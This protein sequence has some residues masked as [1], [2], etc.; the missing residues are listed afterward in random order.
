MA[1]HIDNS[2]VID[3]PLQLVWDMT[4]DIAGWPQLFSEYAETEI[5]A[6]SENTVRFRLTTKPDEQGRVFSWVSER[7]AEPVTW[8]VRARRLDFGVFKYMNLFWEYQEI[9]GA[10]VL[11]RW[12]QD[13]EVRPDAP[14]D[15]AGMTEHLNRHTRTQQQHI[16]KTIE[17]VARKA[18]V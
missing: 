16:K 15:D 3:A 14:A 7:V 6:Q 9:D 12:V 8:T 2:V 13:F 10:G 17:L 11:M 4:N 1:G 18:A 5:L